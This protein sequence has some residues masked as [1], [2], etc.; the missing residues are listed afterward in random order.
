MERQRLTSKG[1]HSIYSVMRDGEELAASLRRAASYSNPEER[2][3]ELR[4]AI[5][6]YLQVIE[7]DSVCRETGLRLTDIW[8]YF[9]HT[10]VNIY[11]SIPGRSMM[12]LIRDRSRPFHPVIGIAGL[13]NSVVQQS[14]R[15]RWI[16][17]DSEVALSNL[18]A[19]PDRRTVRALLSQLDRHIRAIYISDLVEDNLLSRKDLR[20]PNNDIIARLRVEADKA[21]RAHRRYPDPSLQKKSQGRTN[22]EWVSMA[23]SSLF[24]SKRCK[25]L[26]TLLS[27]RGV[28]EGKGIPAASK[29]QLPQLLADGSVKHAFRQLFRFSK[30][31]RVGISMM[32]ITVGGAIAPYNAI[33]G[34]KLVCLLLGSPEIV[35]QYSRKYRQQVSVIASGMKGAKVTRTPRLVLLCTT[36]LYGHGSS[37]YNRI[38]IP[39]E[40]LGG[41]HGDQLRYEELGTS[42]GFGSFHFSAESVRL[43]DALL[44]RSRDGRKVNSIFGEGVNP[45]MRK[46]REALM[47]VGLPSEILLRHGNKRIVYGIPLARNF[48]YVLMGFEKNAKYIIPQADPRTGSALLIDFWVRRW[49]SRRIE[50]PEILHQVAENT[51]AYPV[52]HGAQVK[53]AEER[54]AK[55][56]SIKIAAGSF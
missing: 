40:V 28:L 33:L 10:W 38:K 20:T 35:R 14:I 4:T 3:R 17:W 53:L 2:V 5:D 9:R 37:Q 48:R 11:R 51:L 49:L 8:R 31:E 7:S 54:S 22:K 21:I 39:A 26:A 6:P 34:G 1:W 13:A 19:N 55:V 24:R 27:I 41:V 50:N 12:F 42:E 15:D 47:V 23:E 52:Q 43:A 46:M 56:L 18:Q 25:H 45:L 29:K 16:G 44:G 30:A 36:S 32:D